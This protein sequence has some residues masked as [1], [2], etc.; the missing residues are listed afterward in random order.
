MSSNNWVIHGDHT[1]TGMPLFASDPHLS[2]SIPSSWIIFNMHMP[3]GRNMSGAQLPGIPFLGMGRTNNIVMASTTSRV[4]SADLW[5]EV[6]NEDETEY[7]MDNA[8]HKLDVV[9]ELIK[10]KGQ[11]EPHVL[12]IKYTHRGPVIPTKTLKD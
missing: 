1:E 4:D 9:T 12:N 7:W 10:I 2:N 11:E 8:W 6:L 3:D 5:K